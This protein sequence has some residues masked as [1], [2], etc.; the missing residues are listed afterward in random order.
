MLLSELIN[1]QDR[2]VAITG[3]GADEI[4]LGYD[5]FRENVC[6][7]FVKDKPSSKW[8][9]RIFD[10]LY[11]YL[12]QYKD[13]RIRRLAIDTLLRE[14]N[15]RILNP[16]KSRLNNNLRSFMSMKDSDQIAKESV[17]RLIAE[18]EQKCKHYEFDE[19]DIIQLFEIQNLLS[20]YLLSCQGDRAAMSHSVETRFPYLDIEF[21][22]YCFSIPRNHKLRG[23]FFKKIL[24]KSYES[25]LPDEI[26][27]SPKIAYQAPEARAI[28]KNNKILKS[29]RLASNKI[30]EIY[31]FKKI[32]KILERTTDLS[33]NNRGSFTDNMTVCMISSLSSLLQ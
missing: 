13:K 21:V 6:I 3:E 14:G 17:E 7:N 15:F 26:I 18:Y 9:Y 16:L 4:L 30:Y 5:I 11:S 25:R 32:N 10:N 23:T 1:N 22:K 8:R 24:R 29:L 2:K 31:N 20:G 28:I 12:P 33:G 27:K 19:V